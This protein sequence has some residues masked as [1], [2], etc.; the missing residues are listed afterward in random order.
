MS[1]TT[2]HGLIEQQVQRDPD[3]SAVEHEGRRL[4]Y[5]QLNSRAN[6]FA[7]YLV[8]LG[9]VQNQVVGLCIDRSPEMV[10][11]LLGIMKAGGAYLPLDPNYPRA[12]LE[13]MLEDAKLQVL[14]TETE[15]MGVLPSGEWKVIA[16]D[17]EVE[18]LSG[19]IDDDLGSELCLGG[20]SL[21]YVIYTSGSTGKPKGIA[22]HHGAMVNLIQWQADIFAA[23]GRQRVLQFAALSFDVAFQEMFSTLCTGGTVIL[24]DEWVRRD[25]KALTEFLT[26]N[27]IQRLFVPPVMLHSIAEYCEAAGV[28]PV[29]LRDVIT[30]GEQLRISPSVRNLFQRLSGCKLH[31][32]YGPAETHVVTAETLAGDAWDWPDLPPIGRPIRNAEIYIF[33]E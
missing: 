14:I 15:L 31:N 10:I 28:V 33:D 23:A 5:R 8:N 17:R 24:M 2:V 13:Q 19:F 3:A 12:R 11:G 18:Q 1:I 22:M 27:S 29:G 20:G 30:A 21:V 32:H 16:L 7:R 9:V 6:Q 25:V 26:R 4:T